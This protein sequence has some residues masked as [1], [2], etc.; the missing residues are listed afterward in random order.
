M[1]EC[2]SC[3]TAVEIANGDHITTNWEELPCRECVLSENAKNKHSTHISLQAGDYAR[4]E[5]GLKM[6]ADQ[7]A[8]EFAGAVFFARQDLQDGLRQLL[9][10]LTENPKSATVVLFRI[11]FPERPLR[12]VAEKMGISV[13]AAHSRLKKVRQGW[14][15]LA[16]VIPMKSW[17]WGK[18][19]HDGQEE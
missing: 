18:G 1:P 19:G 3:P 8:G 10:L 2:H 17:E 14:P 15:D 13:Q 9:D 6:A 7:E 16:R 5:M 4:N 12:E 11:C